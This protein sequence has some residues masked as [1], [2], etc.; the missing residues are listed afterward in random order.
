MVEQDTK[1]QILDVAES[2]VQTRGA[3]GMSYQDISQAV[4]IKKASVHHHFPTKEDL[5]EAM[6]ERFGQKFYSVV[7]PLL[8]S[9]LSAPEKL[10]NYLD[11]DHEALRAHKICPYGMLGAE[12]AS[13]GSGVKH[14]VEKFFRDNEQRLEKVLRQGLEEGTFDFAG[15]PRVM[16][17]LIFSY[18]EGALLVVRVRGGL[19]EYQVMTQQLFNLLGCGPEQ[20]PKK[21]TAAKS[22][23]GKTA[24]K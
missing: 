5:L 3:N 1:Q 18:V 8:A 12:L 10:R 9:D 6:L 22:R 20:A 19:D 4:G 14:Q 11:L 7:D 15:D 16:A 2:L 24:T 21:R 23:R 13:M 17:N